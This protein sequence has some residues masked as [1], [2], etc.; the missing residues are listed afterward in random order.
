[1]LQVYHNPRCK[2]SRSVVNE[3][4]ERGIDFEIIDY[5]KNIPSVEELKILLTKLHLK[6]FD[7]VRKNEK[8]F[9]EKFHKK[10]FTNEEWILILR[11]YPILIERP[12]VARKNKAI[13]C[14]PPERL[15]EIL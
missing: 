14:R 15:E 2:I 10:N 7:I 11:E 13:I 12:I 6:P 5:L 8:I 1:M 4:R 9:K 3:L